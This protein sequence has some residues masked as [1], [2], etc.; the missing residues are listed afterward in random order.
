MKRYTNFVVLGF[1]ALVLVVLA[2]C[3]PAAAPSA[4]KS[5]SDAVINAGSIPPPEELRVGEYLNYYDQNFPAPVDSTVGLDLRLGNAQIPTSGG[6]AWLQVGLQARDGENEIIAP[7]NLALVIDRSGSMDS[8]DKMP[9]VK[10]A[11]KVFLHSLAPN[12]IASIVAYNDSAHVIAPS[13]QVGDGRWIDNAV[14]QL[15]PGGGTNLNEGLQRGFEEVER[16]FDIRR[17]NRVV[18][19]TD[20][21]ANA[22]VTSPDQIAGMAK[23]YND[24]GI[25]LST[26]GLGQEFNDAL[27]SQLARQGKGAYHFVATA[28]DMDKIFRQDVTGLI[29]KA[30]ANVRVIVNPEPGVRVRS[31]TGYDGTP[32]AGPLTVKLHDMGTGDPQVVLVQL[33]VPPSANGMRPL[34]QVQLQYDDLFTQRPGEASGTAVADA[35]VMPNYEPLWDVE[36]L[37]NVTIQRTA[38]GLK[39][40]ALLY[41]AERYEEA[42]QLAYQLEQQLRAVARLTEDEQL[43]K[44]ADTMQRYEQTLS[45]W[46]EHETGRVPQPAY[47]QPNT[48]GTQHGRLPTPTVMGTEIEVE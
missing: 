32:P 31:V 47:A 46:V 42:W 43:A 3:A 40:I 35:S 27:L 10:Q 25:Y 39:Q 45:K 11:L 8:P 37:R 18:L 6:E 20:G 24:K 9:L 13:Q 30:A 7:L 14:E 48:G 21:L 4:S 33:D 12:D 26:I 19:L 15:A 34:A 2:A 29:Q 36:V 23:S 17:N 38:Q 5:R 44:D 28:H 22:G 1:V 16:N 41:Q